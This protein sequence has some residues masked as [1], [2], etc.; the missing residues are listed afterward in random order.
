[1]TCAS[2]GGRKIWHVAQAP[3]D[4]EHLS[5]SVKRADLVSSVLTVI[6]G[7]ADVNSSP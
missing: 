2:A 7:N 5:K 6:K 1:M 3:R 4:V